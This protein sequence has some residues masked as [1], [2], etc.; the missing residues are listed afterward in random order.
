VHAKPSAQKPAAQEVLQA[1]L[2]GAEYV[3]APQ[4][5]H[6]VS[7]SLPEGAALYLPA[8]HGEHLLSASLPVVAALYLPA[9]QD[10]QSV[11]ASLPVVAAYLP[12]PQDKHLV[13][14]SLPVVAA[15]LPAPQF[16][17]AP[18][19]VAP[20]ML[21]YLPAAH[22]WRSVQKC[23]SVVRHSSRLKAT[24]TIATPSES[25]QQDKKR[26]GAWLITVQTSAV[27]PPFAPM[28][29]PAGQSVQ[30]RDPVLDTFPAG[31][32]V[33]AVS[34]MPPVVSISFRCLLARGAISVVM[35]AH[36]GGFQ[37]LSSSTGDARR[38]ERVVI[39]GTGSIA[40]DAFDT[41]LVV[42]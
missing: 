38:V 2:P 22:G 11:S 30:E 41:A 4:A 40:E 31:Q 10:E 18:T 27:F 39:V 20:E 19:S 15:Y 14:A 13:S 32:A 42:A 6:L 29:F 36:T 28:Y 9:P 24:D 25:T 17:H 21:R 3:P 37:E 33:H 5:K 26:P 7:A 23:S 1:A 35:H 34:V 8:A 16:E 12:A